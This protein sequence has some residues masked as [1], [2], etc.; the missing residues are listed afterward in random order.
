MNGNLNKR[1]AII[2]ST[3]TTKDWFTLHCEVPL[4]DMFGYATELRSLT[5]G[6]GEFA[7]EYSKYLPASSE[8]TAKLVSLANPQKTDP[9]KQK[10]KN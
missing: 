5:Q 4:N 2:T 6:K 3:E 8:T 10:K 9:K 7:M 1:N